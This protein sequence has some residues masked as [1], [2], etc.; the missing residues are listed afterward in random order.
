MEALNEL[1]VRRCMAVVEEMVPSWDTAESTSP[2]PLP[3]MTALGMAGQFS[4]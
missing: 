4:S 2:L 1:V 3:G